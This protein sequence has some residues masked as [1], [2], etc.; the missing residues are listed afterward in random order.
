MKN[1]NDDIKELM[2]KSF[3][4]L[5]RTERVSRQR[6]HHYIRLNQMQD[7]NLSRNIKNLEDKYEKTCIRSRNNLE[8]E[9]ER[10]EI[11]HVTIQQISNERQHP[12]LSINKIHTKDETKQLF[13]KSTGK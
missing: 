1:K 4:K 7:Q 12:L 6:R 9:Q 10:K 3:E 8:F 5:K 13:P 11:L 2:S